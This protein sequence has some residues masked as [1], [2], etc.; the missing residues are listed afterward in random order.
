MVPVTIG[1]FPKSVGFTAMPT[2]C[3]CPFGGNRQEC[4]LQTDARNHA[5]NRDHQ[6]AGE[7]SRV[8]VCVTAARPSACALVG[9]HAVDRCRI[10]DF[11]DE[12]VVVERRR[13]VRAATTLTAGRCA[14]RRTRRQ[15]EDGLRA[16]TTGTGDAHLR[17]ERRR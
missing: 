7:R 2:D 8:I 6:R 11:D 5:A 14:D 3:G 10:V 9:N 4:R 16:P 15:I 13:D 12:G 1:L 17:A